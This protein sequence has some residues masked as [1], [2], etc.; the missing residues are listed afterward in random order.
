M[1][2]PELQ[3]PDTAKSAYDIQ[4]YKLALGYDRSAGD[5]NATTTITATAKSPTRT[6]ALDFQRVPEAVTVNGVPAT[7][8]QDGDTTVITLSKTLPEGEKLTIVITYSITPPATDDGAALPE[9]KAPE[10]ET[11]LKDSGLP[12]GWLP[13]NTRPDAA[14]FDLVSALP[15]NLTAWKTAHGMRYLEHAVAKYADKAAGGTPADADARAAREAA[16][17]QAF[18]ERLARWKAAH[19]A[20]EGDRADRK[21]AWEAR[22]AEWKRDHADRH[23]NAG[24]QARWDGDDRHDGDRGERGD[25]GRRGE[26][27]HHG[28]QGGHGDHG[29]R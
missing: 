2:A 8:T 17:R 4:N 25:R 18:A 13:A 12:A 20:A 6:F 5:V 14:R 3:A 21:A 28:H 9:L 29:G 23:G 15:A 1:T 27:H 24:S 26:G 11:D 10:G 19:E 7:V 16:V 22:R